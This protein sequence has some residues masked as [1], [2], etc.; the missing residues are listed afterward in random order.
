MAQTFPLLL[1]APPCPTPPCSR[2][3]HYGEDRT[4][5]TLPVPSLFRPESDSACATRSGTEPSST[6]AAAA[7]GS[8]PVGYPEPYQFVPAAPP[9]EPLAFS[10]WLAANLPLSSKYRSEHALH[11][12]MCVHTCLLNWQAAI[13]PLRSKDACVCVPCSMPFYM[14]VR[15]WNTCACT[16]AQVCM[17][18]HAYKAW[19]DHTQQRCL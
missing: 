9:Q 8:P 4:Q 3:D 16:S 6:E 7:A 15:G 2:Q 14:S 10:N 18:V 13:L 12:C 11:A 17:R 5:A 1:T 19:L